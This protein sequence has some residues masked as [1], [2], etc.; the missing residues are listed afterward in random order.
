MCA[1]GRRGGRSLSSANSD[2]HFDSRAFGTTAL[3]FLQPPGLTWLLT[4]YL[5][6]SPALTRGASS[7]FRLTR[8]RRKIYSTSPGRAT[9]RS[10]RAINDPTTT[11]TAS[12]MMSSSTGETS[13]KQSQRAAKNATPCVHAH[14]GLDY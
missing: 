3:G 11:S 10:R 6:V 1:Q 4:N 13:P 12:K 8:P 5:E 14:V 7:W 2:V 9:N